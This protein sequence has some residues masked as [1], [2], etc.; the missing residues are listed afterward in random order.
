VRFS[1]TN[2]PTAVAFAVCCAGVGLFSVMDALMK[3]LSLAIGAYNALLWRGVAGLS[4]GGV[5]MLVLR[6]PWPTAAVMRLHIVRGVVCAFMALTFFWA[7]VR[8]PMAEA[9]AL[10]FIAPLIALYLAALMLGETIGRAAIIASVLG[11]AGI[12]VILAGR[13]GGD[14][15]PDALWGVGA[16][17]VSAVLFAW[18][19]ILQ[20]RQAQL[21]SPI[22]I[23]FYQNLVVLVVMACAAPWL[24]V[25]PAASLIPLIAGAAALAFTSL[26]CLSW[27]YARAEAQVL[28]PVEYT[29]FLWSALMG[30]MVFHEPLA[31][32]TL[33]GAALIV[34]GC[35]I[36]ARGKP[37]AIPRTEAA[38]A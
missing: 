12:G 5:A 6:A 22:E 11:I 15:R 31:L 8:L 14:H 28:I 29:A 24:G 36:A 18:N 27:A 10:S 23:A 3:G 34:A 4:L 35:I 17:L 32:T 13:I 37:A 33:A 9:I 25:F 20:R 19:L 16:V 26:L 7:L 21:A 2:T 38:I 30:W 1:Q